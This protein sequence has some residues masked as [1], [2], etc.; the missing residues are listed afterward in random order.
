[1]STKPDLFQ[2]LGQLQASY[3]LAY[4]DLSDEAKKSFSPVVIQRWMTG[5]CSKEQVLMYA[6]IANRFVF[7]LGKH[8]EILFKLFA[9]CSL[10]DD[11]RFK[12]LK[13]PSKKGKSKKLCVQL[14]A[15][16]LQCS[17]REAEEY[18]SLLSESDILDMAK[19]AGLQDD[20]IKK[21][22]EELK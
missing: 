14:L 6:N 15:S 12:W 20:E 13:G 11:Q 18:L 16:E 1:M 7:S 8:P 5:A 4:D 19:S 22:K 3:P 17:S 9:A 10:D 21:I 2:F